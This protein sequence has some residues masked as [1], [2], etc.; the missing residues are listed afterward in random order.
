MGRTTIVLSGAIIATIWL[1]AGAFAEPI[2]EVTVISGRDCRFPD[3][4]YNSVRGE[5]LVVWADYTTGARGV[6]GKRVTGDGEPAGD[7][8]RISPQSEKEAF[9]PAIVHCAAIDEYH[10]QRHSRAT[11]ARR[12]HIGG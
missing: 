8:F 12:R 9:F 1:S 4:A 3:A 11:S 7:I 2:G 5:Y 6:F 10:Q